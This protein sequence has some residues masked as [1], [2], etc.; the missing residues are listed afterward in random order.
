[1]ANLDFIILTTV[2]VIVFAIFSLSL[3]RGFGSKDGI[4]EKS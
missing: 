1:M 3:L 2:V 4:K